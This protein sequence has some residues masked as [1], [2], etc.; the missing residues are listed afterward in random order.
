M[1]GT[2]I[3]AAPG[4]RKKKNRKSVKSGVAAYKRRSWRILY[5]LRR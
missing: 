2:V 3:V 5:L 1:F 4:L